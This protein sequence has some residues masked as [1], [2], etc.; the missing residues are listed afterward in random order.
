MFIDPET[1]PAYF[2]P[3]SIQA[4]HAPR[5]HEI[6]EKARHPHKEHDEEGTADCRREEKQDRGAEESETCHQ[7]ASK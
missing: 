7:T 6:I 2:P 4:D 1:V 3:T 5:H